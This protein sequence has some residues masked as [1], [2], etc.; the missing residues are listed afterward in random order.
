[1]GVVTVL[2]WMGEG[3]YGWLCASAG[4]A[5]HEG[6]SGEKMN[7]R[8]GGDTLE[9]RDGGST[10]ALLQTDQAAPLCCDYGTTQSDPGPGLTAVQ[11]G[12]R[13]AGPGACGPLL[14]PPSMRRSASGLHSGA[15]NVSQA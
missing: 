11:A 8:H 12:S 10:R 2:T 4:P 14:R 7:C 15:C 9:Q 1:M 3:L 13:D 5:V 6:S